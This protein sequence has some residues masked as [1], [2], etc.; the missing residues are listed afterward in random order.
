MTRATASELPV[1]LDEVAEIGVEAVPDLEVGVVGELRVGDGLAVTQG[2]R[3]PVGQVLRRGLDQAGVVVTLRHQLRGATDGRGNEGDPLFQR[4]VDGHRRILDK[5]RHHCDEVALGEEGECLGLVLVGD[6][7]DRALP[8]LGLLGEVVLGRHPALRGQPAAPLAEEGDG[9]RDLATLVE[10]VDRVAEDL[11]ALACLEPAEEDQVPALDH[12]AVLARGAGSGVDRRDVG[13]VDDVGLH[14]DVGLGQPVADPVHER[15][16]VRGPAD[17]HVGE[18]DALLLGVRR[19]DQV[20]VG[21]RE[22]LVVPVPDVRRR[23]LDQE[24][25]FAE[26]EP[27]PLGHQRVDQ[28]AAPLGGVDDVERLLVTQPLVGAGVA[29]LPVRGGAPQRHLRAHR[30][31]AA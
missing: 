18:L 20:G 27:E 11:D 29:A 9:V 14:E 19:R 13:E 22:H 2:D 10:Q 31:S 6:R 5:G 30:G 7:D 16:Q 4:L 1:L 17:H 23:R 15:Q 12:V 3:E 26:R 21:D 28:A 8:G 24:Q 25:R